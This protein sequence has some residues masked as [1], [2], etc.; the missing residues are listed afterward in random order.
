M[1]TV[2][3]P[4]PSPRVDDDPHR[5]P[6]GSDTECVTRG[7][8]SRFYRETVYCDTRTKADSIPNQSEA[9]VSVDDRLCDEA[10]LVVLDGME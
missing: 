8:C 2:P 5:E 3:L 6:A 10:F 4:D 7:K 1:P 9:G